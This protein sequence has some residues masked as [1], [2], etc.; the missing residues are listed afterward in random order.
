[1]EKVGFIGVG[2]IGLA[3]SKNLIERG[4]PVVGYRRSSLAEFEAAGGI[5]ARSPAEVGAAADI[6]FSC[7]PD[8]G[9]LEEV[10][11]G[12][13]GLLKSA[14]PGQVV[15]EFGSF[16]VPVK[17]RYIAP[18]A[19]KGAIFLD[20]EVSGTPGM[21]AARKAYIYLA[22]DAAAAAKAEPIVRQFSD[23]YLYLGAFGAATQVKLVNN[24]LVALNIAGTAQAM[25]VGLKLGIDPKLLIEAV[26]KGSGGSTMFN[27]RAPW[28]AERAFVPIQG[29]AKA[30]VS[31]VHAIRGIAAEAGVATDLIDSLASI[32]DRAVPVIGERDVAAII[33]FFDPKP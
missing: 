12:P 9:A 2:R 28:M 15:V 20:G 21:V 24:L 1:M 27:I 32:Y 22:G 26:S 4:V 18:L 33:D 10:V 13:N 3:I 5:A 14:R 7:L 31:Y 16:P 11:S 17:S 23:L 25:A 29:S 30:L 8:A 6:V 19:D